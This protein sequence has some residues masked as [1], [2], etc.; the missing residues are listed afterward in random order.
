MRM[1]EGD[2][3]RDALERK[4]RSLMSEET[5]GAQHAPQTAD[6]RRDAFVPQLSSNCRQTIAYLGPRT[7]VDT[8][9]FSRTTTRPAESFSLVLIAGNSMVDD[10]GIGPSSSAG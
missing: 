8:L 10:A 1:V 5:Q 9:A 2:D 4:E 6:Q 3:L 7:M